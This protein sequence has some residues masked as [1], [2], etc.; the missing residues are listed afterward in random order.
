[1]SNPIGGRLSFKIDSVKYKAKGAFTYNLGRDKQE[2]VVGADGVHGPKLT[3]QI[4]FIE[5]AITNDGSV[6]TAV[7]VGS[8]NVTVTLELANG[9]T[10]VLRDAWHAGEGSTG[11]EEGEMSIRFE[12]MAAEEI[13]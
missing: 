8:R 12:G 4:P 1:M 11:S 5:G 7:L 9:K 3:P 2:G 13:F 6:D 10:I